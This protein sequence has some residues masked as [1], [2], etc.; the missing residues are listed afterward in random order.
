MSVTSKMHQ[1]PFWVFLISVSLL[2]HATKS[3]E[4]E[5][6][7]ALLNFFTK[8]S[9]NNG[10]IDPTLGWNS[11]SDPCRDQWKGI[12]CDNHNLSVK[13][14]FLDGFNFSGTFDAS[15]LCNVQSLVATL[16]VISLNYNN[17]RG[18]N[19]EEIANCK[20]LT[21]FHISRNQFSGSLPN[22]L[23]RLNNLKRL[24]ISYNNFSGSLP[25]LA[26]IS[27][28]TVF[29]AQNNDL[30]GAIPN[31]D[32]ANLEEFDVSFNNFSGPIPLGGV[33]FWVS[34]YI[35]NPEL[36]GDPLPNRCPTHKPK[37]GV[38]K[39]QILMFSGYFLI[40]LALFL[41]II[42]K[43]FCKKDGTKEEKNDAVYKVA[44]LD[45]SSDNP[46]FTTNEHKIGMSKSE[47]SNASAD[48]GLVSSSLVVLSSPE[49][50]G[51]RFENLLKAPAELIGRGKH[52]SVY[53][54]I[55]EDQGKPLAVKRIKD[56][57]I[58]SYD[59][60]QRMRRLDQVKHPNVLPAMAF[61]SSRQEKL[62]VYEYQQNGSLFRL[63]H[64]TQMSKALD[65]SSRLGI[66]ATIAEA[67]AFMHQELRQ[68]RIAH[69]N[70]K[71]SNI[72]LNNSMEPC[73]SEYGLMVV[74][75]QDRS[76][77]A[78]ASVNSIQAAE[79][80]A[81]TIFKSDIFGF[82][83]ILLE[84]L[85]GKMV[86]NNGVDLAQWVVLVVREEWTVEVFDKTL[87]QDGTSEERMLN[88][89][90]VAIKCVNRSAES[91]PSI[92]QAALMLNTIK[93]EDERSMDV[94]EQ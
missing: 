65:W 94:S 59:F 66:A 91:R 56:W 60:K 71:S 33:S 92:N 15:T 5:A 7:R 79:E 54:V 64:G 40:G 16:G 10:S 67:L 58:S 41:V 36:C 22:S 77:S 44:A 37:G 34:S 39:N 23:S 48:S 19:L 38:S 78:T 74:E 84:L 57:T 63:L 6:K 35:D 86:Q 80:S 88:L 21:R 82:G 75:D 31:F 43:L 81:D 52:G 76:V 12:I 93:E 1:I 32:F 83:V 73:I 17:L 85:T 45:D 14:I 90:R 89:L 13:K 18:E 49:V 11:T 26:R 25:E 2:L 24:E 51:L 61:Y 8:L 28:L 55:C 46:S 9:T 69:G 72:L 50:N 4:E 87:I 30:S 47:I 62:L 29:L 42:L 70:L 68:D 3:D 20:Q 27:G 53:K